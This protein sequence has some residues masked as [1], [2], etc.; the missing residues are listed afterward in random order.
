MTE[1]TIAGIKVNTISLIET[2]AQLKI[3]FNRFQTSNTELQTEFERV[4]DAFVWP[5]LFQNG[6]H[7]QKT[8]CWCP[9]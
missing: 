7:L 2:S 4:C 1:E 8:T 3:N 9:K 6:E 5:V